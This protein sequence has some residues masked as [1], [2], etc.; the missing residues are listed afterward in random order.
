VGG[1]SFIWRKTLSLF[2]VLLLSSFI[3]INGWLRMILYLFRKKKKLRLFKYLRIIKIKFK[4]NSIKKKQQK[5][6]EL[7]NMRYI[8][9]NFIFKVIAS[10]RLVILI[11]ISKMILL[12]VKPNSKKWWVVNKFGSLLQLGE[13][14]FAVNYILHELPHKKLEKTSYELQNVS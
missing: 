8:L 7:K 2:L 6:I 14:N 11:H 10:I 1:F 5:A 4:T 3:F 12:N 13:K 9:L